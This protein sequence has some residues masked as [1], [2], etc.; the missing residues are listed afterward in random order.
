MDREGGDCGIELV[1][2]GVCVMYIYIYKHPC[3]ANTTPHLYHLI[4]TS[5][6]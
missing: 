2:E 4:L 3:I 5:A 1:G 6:T